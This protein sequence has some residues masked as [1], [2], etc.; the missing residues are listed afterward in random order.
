[1]NENILVSFIIP[2]YNTQVESIVRCV[3]SINDQFSDKIEILIVDDG[4]KQ[5]LSL[6]YDNKVASLR[7]VQLLHIENAGAANARNVGIERARGEYI[8]FVDSDDYIPSKANLRNLIGRSIDENLDLLIGAYKE[9]SESIDKTFSA[10]EIQLS[11][12]KQ[13]FEYEF[14]EPGSPWSKVFKRSFLIDNRILFNKS[15]R[16]S[17]DRV[18]MLEVFEH[19]PKFNIVGDLCYCFCVEEGNSLTRAYNPKT[20]IYLGAFFDAVV[21]FV[22]INHN[23]H[24]FGH[25]LKCLA[26]ILNRQCA[27][28]IYFH[29]L[30]KDSFFKRYQS[31]K[32]N[33]PKQATI[34]NYRGKALAVYSFLLKYRMV[35]ALSLILEINKY[36]YYGK[37][38][39]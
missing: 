34:V 22:K 19:N 2:L 6:E 4:S 27:Q 38:N 15:L 36:R 8:I 33:S 25:A 1:M 28:Q 3:T 13:N 18:F 39:H 10:E 23:N 24:E 31:F 37:L 11:I 29:P 30:N 21:E 32:A 20:I 12:I 17:H 5:D 9:H 7:N 35:F 14:V 26:M 16:R